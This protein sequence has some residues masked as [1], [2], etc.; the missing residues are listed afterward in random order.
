VTAFAGKGVCHNA[1]RLC[2]HLA[3]IPFIKVNKPAIANVSASHAHKALEFAPPVGF[4]FGRSSGATGLSTAPM[5][6]FSATNL[7]LQVRITENVVAHHRI[8]IENI[9]P[10]CYT[11]CTFHF[12]ITNIVF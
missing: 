11:S 4:A 1:K 2:A 7:R 12:A 5:M 3:R 8:F 6:K 9:S 10:V